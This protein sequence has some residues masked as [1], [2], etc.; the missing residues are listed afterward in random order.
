MPAATASVSKGRWPTSSS[1]RRNASLPQARG[2]IG[3]DIGAVAQA[4]SGVRQRL[5]DVIVGLAG[6]I[7]CALP[8]KRVELADARFQILHELADLA[9]DLGD[10]VGYGAILACHGCSPAEL[11]RLF[12]RIAKL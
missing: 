4:F 1:T 6:S 5:R 12:Q 9:F 3:D 2:L 10:V 8:R 7:G 11:P